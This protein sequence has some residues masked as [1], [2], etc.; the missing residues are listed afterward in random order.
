MTQYDERVETQRLKIEA[1]KWAKGVKCIHAHSI[2]SMHYDD[3]PQ[4]TDGKSVLDVEYN[5]GSVRRTTADNETLILG[6][7]LRGQDLLDSYTRAK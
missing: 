1:E 5:D 6:T 3:R 2:S 4:D 7:P